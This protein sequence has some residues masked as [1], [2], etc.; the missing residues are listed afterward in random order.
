MACMEH[1]CIGCGHIELNN[2]PRQRPPCPKCGCT[3][4]GSTCDEIPERNEEEQD[5]SDND[6]S[7]E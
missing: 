5:D 7:C 6:N 3:R 2:E 4:W 1:L